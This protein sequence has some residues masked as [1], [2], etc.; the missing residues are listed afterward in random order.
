M[1][2]TD[3]TD[4]VHHLFEPD[5]ALIREHLERLFRR[6]PAEYP[7]G[8]IEIAWSDRNGQITKALTF[9]SNAAGIDSAI[10][11]AIERNRSAANVYVG[12]NPRKPGTTRWRAHADD[13]EI[14]FFHFVECDKAES[15]ALLRS[16]PLPYCFAVVTGRR[17]HDRVHG[18]WELATPTRDLATWAATQRALQE[19]FKGDAMIDP[20]RVL[21]LAGTVSYPPLHK[22]TRGYKIEP[23]TIRTRYADEAGEPHERQPVIGEVLVNAYRPAEPLSAAPEPEQPG[24][25]EESSDKPNFGEAGFDIAGRIDAIRRGEE[26]HNNVLALIAHLV[27]SGYAEAVILAMAAE[28]TMAGWTVDQTRADLRTMIDGARQKWTPDADDD[29]DT[30]DYDAAPPPKSLGEWD[31]GEADYDNIPPRG[32]LLG[33]TFC[34]GFVSGLIGEG[35]AGKTALRLAQCLAIATGRSDLTGEHVFVRGNVLLLVLEDGRA[36]IMRRLRAAMLHHKIDKEDIKGRLFVATLETFNEKLATN[37]NG[38]TRTGALKAMLES[39]IDERKIDLT[40]IDPLKRAHG[41]PEND[42]TGMDYVAAL[43]TEIAVTR[44]CAVDA[45][46]HQTKGG[47]EPGNADRGRG[48]SS[49]KD[50]GRLIY[51]MTPMSKQEAQTLGVD[52][53]E[54]RSLR[55]IDSAKVNLCPPG[56]TRWFQLISVALGNGTEDYPS[57]DEVQSVEVW[58]PP[59]VFRLL[60]IRVIN[61]ILDQIDNGLPGDPPGRR[62]SPTPRDSDRAAWAVVQEHSPGLTKEQC[63]HVIKTWVKNEVLKPESYHDPEQRRERQGLIVGQRPGDSW[64]T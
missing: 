41:I 52:E 40:V 61:Q 58:T 15:L 57:G 44:D 38:E 42:N 3:D 56:E 35:A 11:C 31:A 5:A 14:S 9:P 47:S 21:R 64:E 2:V 37:V 46:Y 17:P 8:L 26:W 60:T 27:T 6:C 22:L 39:T 36:E 30:E 10:E 7:G 33:N 49:Y 19:H 45:P 1:A 53:T 43:L 20:P 24:R 4:N 29:T 32:W 48:A 51:T 34:R 12:A 63:Q 55:R 54:R 59:D 50:A 62:Y 23:V 16:A 13:V 18:Y 28:L 25:S